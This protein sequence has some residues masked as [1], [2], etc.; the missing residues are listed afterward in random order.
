MTYLYDNMTDLPDGQTFTVN[1]EFSKEGCST[2]M[3]DLDRS[4]N[5]GIISYL[6]G[7]AVLHVLKFVGVIR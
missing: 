3:F 6:V 4:G 5:A 1:D 2:S 7:M